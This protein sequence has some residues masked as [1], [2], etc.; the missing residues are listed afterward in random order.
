MAEPDI[1]IPDQG[2]PDM[3]DFQKGP[4]YQQYLK[5][6]RRQITEY[7][8]S[9]GISNVNEIIDRNEAAEVRA[10]IKKIMDS[11][12]PKLM[13]NEKLAALA[14]RPTR[15]ETAT[16]YYQRKFPGMYFRF[17]NR[18]DIIQSDWMSKGMKKTVAIDDKFGET[19]QFIYDGD[20]VLMQCPRQVYVDNVRKPA[21]EKSDYRKQALENIQQAFEE[22][23]AKLGVETF[24]KRKAVVTDEP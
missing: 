9:K 3:E 12:K 20:L 11:N 7:L 24:G 5:T 10:E 14:G 22:D 23:G 16:E 6:C 18:N 19:G 1:K 8:A 21:K 4:E 17:C 2:E 13:R 15:F